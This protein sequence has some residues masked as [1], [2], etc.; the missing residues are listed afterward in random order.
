MLNLDE[1]LKSKNIADLLE[2]TE[3]SKIGA[4]AKEGYE[5]DDESLRDWKDRT[6]MAMKIAKQTPE[7]KT[8]PFPGAANVKY[9]LITRAAIDFA[10]RT[11]PELVQGN[12]VVKASVTGEDPDELKAKRAARVSA[13]MS[14]QLLT[15]S[16]EWEEGTDKLL[17]V[18][19]VVGTVFRKT[20]RDPVSSQNVSRFCLPDQVIVNYNSPSL[21]KARRITHLMPMYAN[22]IVEYIREGIFTDCDVELLKGSEGFS[23]NDPD[24]PLVIAEQHCYLD[25]DDDGYQ[26]PYCV[27][28]HKSSGKVLRIYPAFKKANIKRTRT[29]N[30]KKITPIRYFTDYHCIPSPDGGFYSLGLGQL[31]YPINETINTTLNQLLDAGKLAN[32]Q[33]GIIGRGLRIKAGELKIPMGTWKVLD[34]AAG[35]DIRNNIVQFPYKEPS[36][37]LF[38]LLSL[39]VEVGRDLSSVQDVMQG[40]GQTQNVPATTILTMVEQGLKIFNAIQKRLYRSFKD[41]FKKLFDLNH[42]HLSNEEYKAI[43]DDE[44]AD[45][46]KDFNYEDYDICPV[47]D[48]TA[49]SDLQRI[50]RARAVAEIPGLNPRSVQ[51]MMLE[52]LSLTPQQIEALLPP[53]NPP[54]PPEMIKMQAEAE[55]IQSKTVT[56]QITQTQI[57]A[58]LDLNKQKFIVDSREA[59]ARIQKMEHDAIV[60][61]QKL[62]NVD[63][64]LELQAITTK[65]KQDLEREKLAVQAALKVAELGTKA[66]IDLEK[67]ANDNAKNSTD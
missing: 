34:T 11:Y 23:I 40:K 63:D 64:K 45:V 65:L 22:E 26:E 33:G 15:E 49:S 46:K 57:A 24:P 18:L 44:E 21:K 32:M 4:Q 47:A 36:S 9:P 35:T 51:K 25:L 62:G 31:L 58:G 50:T 37:V 19:A 43:L 48:P 59:L 3:L 16:D 55:L 14:Y 30:V 10:S 28:F 13:C 56:E 2:D 38:Q 41:E 29:G 8:T 53:E 42:E 17:H 52:A 61:Y 27:T 39:L 60:N 5:V 66:E 20:Y 12:K 54:P 67:I 6:E 1:I 7:Q